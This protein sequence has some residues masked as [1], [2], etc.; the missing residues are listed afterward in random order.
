MARTKRREG[1]A[2]PAAAFSPL[3]AAANRLI[4]EP[5]GLLGRCLGIARAIGDQRDTALRPLP[6]TIGPLTSGGSRPDF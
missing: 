2:D 4:A 3:R 5:G 6:A 1:G